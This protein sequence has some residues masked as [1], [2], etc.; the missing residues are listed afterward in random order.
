M[1]I[2]IGSNGGLTGV[3]LAKQFCKMK[4]VTVYGADSSEMNVGHLFV[5]KQFF[6]PPASEKTFIECLI[7]LLNDNKIDIYLPTHSKEIKVISLNEN[8]LR[9]KV[10][11]KFIVSPFQTFQDLDNKSI[12]N[13]KLKEVG[14]PVP[15][16]IDNYICQYPIIMKHDICS[17]S[18]GTKIIDNQRIHTAYKETYKDVSFYQKISGVE[19][20][21]DCMFDNRGT[22]IGFNQRQR[23]KTIGGAVS[24]T[25]NTNDFNI[26]PWIE[27]I[28]KK[29]KFCGCVN[30]QYIVQNNI[31][32]FIDINLRYPSGGLP[33]SVESGLNIP[34]LII[35]ILTN[36]Q[37]N[38]FLMPDNN[39][40]L[41][42][43]RYFE[44]K[45]P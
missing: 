25:R 11:T 40:K 12:A 8:F 18:V 28:S 1:R 22:L 31:P 36:R 34:Q 30:F 32:Y 27:I 42:M 38:K 24:I 3:Y 43:Y 37:I 19:Y 44:E 13:K 9:S 5:K 17:G 33:L 35:D 2:L 45:R 41:T 15:Q 16:L 39:K 23:I 21:V 14:I 6:L 29:W 10:I 7:S 26:L 4:D 20:T